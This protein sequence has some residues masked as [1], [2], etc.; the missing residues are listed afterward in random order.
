MLQC[1]KTLDFIFKLH[2]LILQLLT[3]NIVFLSMRL[4]LKYFLDSLILSYGFDYLSL[5][6]IN[7]YLTGRKQRVRVN[8]SFSEW[9]NVNYG[10]P[11]GSVLGPKLYNYNSSDLF[12]FVLFDIGKYADDNSPFSVAQTI[13]TVISNLEAEAKNLLSWIKYNGMSAN[14][15][16]FHLVE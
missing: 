5:K 13:P 16:K 8:A 14:P 15:D 6:L 1:C 10:V 9:S 2:S 11:Q 4:I 3:T 7:N 12:L